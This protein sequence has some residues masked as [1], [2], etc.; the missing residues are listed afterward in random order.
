MLTLKSFRFVYRLRAGQY[1]FAK[2]HTQPNIWAKSFIA[3]AL[4]YRLEFGRFETKSFRHE[5]V[6]LHK[7]VDQYKYSLRVNMKNFLGEYS[8]FLK[9][10]TLSTIRGTIIT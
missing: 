4:I 9:P 6:K 8:S 3:A 1:F 10:S 7:N 5:A 2:V